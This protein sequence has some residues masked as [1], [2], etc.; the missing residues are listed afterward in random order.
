MRSKKLGL[1]LSIWIMLSLVLTASFA[2][3]V[4]AKGQAG[5][6]IAKAK[7]A[8][9]YTA[10]RDEATKSGAKIV[11]DLP[12]LNTLV[13]QASADSQVQLSGSLHLESLAKDQVRTLIQPEGMQTVTA[14][15][16]GKL[17]ERTRVK[18]DPA[19][20]N[21]GLMW[22]LDR[23]HT[24]EA[25]KYTTGKSSVIVGVAD[26]G[27]DYT[28]SELKNQVLDVVD[29]TD[30]TLCK[31]YYG[32]SDS[33]LPAYFGV[34]PDIAPV[35]GDW[36]GHGSWIGGNIAGALDK[37]GINGIAPNTK[38]V[39]LK[40]SEWCG[41]AYDSS[42]LNAFIYAADHGIDVV[43]ISFGG[44]LDRSDPQQDAIYKAY[45]DV[46]NY[47]WNKGTVIVAAAGNEHLRIGDGGKV[48]S[49]GPLTIPGD[50]F[51]DYYGQY[52][53]PGGIKHVVNVSATGNVVNKSSAS[54][55]TGTFESSDATCKPSSDAHQ[56]A[57]AG[58]KNQ[59]TYY[60]NY[61]PRIDIAAPGGAREFN[62]PNADRG[63]T[64]GFPYTAVDGTTA[65]EEFSITSNW[66]TQIPCFL[67]GDPNFYQ[68]ECYSTIQGT[69]MA[70]PHVSAVIALVASYN[71]AIRHNPAKLVAAVKAGAT[72]ISGN[73]TQPLSATD[74]SAGDRTGLLCP[75]GYCHLGGKAISDREAYGAGLVNALG[76]ILE[77]KKYNGR[78][79]Q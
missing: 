50:P 24:Q 8:A 57:G 56:P 48:L 43:S 59:L 52:E 47:A 39:A 29:L 60:S 79:S 10:L 49:H 27:L 14:L 11:S 15:K 19:S 54:C 62:L 69:S 77:S 22:N 65:W 20:S 68:N 58:K 67:I 73:A 53:T 7:S 5:R 72:N 33:E 1:S 74:T 46:V 38:L 2:T 61:G 37:V 34:S 66:A 76:A 70:T 4:S 28:H 63:G 55:P 30:P 75:T 32:L 36:N 35:N 6:Y 21:P 3:T 26:T 64:G 42:I 13:V 25:W 31:D 12:E 41:S 51:V 17:P 45:E 40:I 23:I 78:N 18:A 71:P 16:Q 44:Y 9:D